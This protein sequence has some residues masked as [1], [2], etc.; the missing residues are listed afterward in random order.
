MACRN[1]L[2]ARRSKRK[3]L[4]A[5]LTLRI[6]TQFS[7]RIHIS[8]SSPD[9]RKMLPGAGQGT[10]QVEPGDEPRGASIVDI[11]TVKRSSDE[12]ARAAGL[13]FELSFVVP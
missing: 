6:Q 9:P 3:C 11:P 1:S 2:S 4:S 8:T 12:R 13:L 7:C 5:C 10:C